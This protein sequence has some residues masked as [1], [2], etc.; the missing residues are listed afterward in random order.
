M[1]TVDTV[2]GPL[3]L[4]DLGVTLMHEHILAKCKEEQHPL[5][6]DYAVS[7]LMRARRAGVN[8][9]VEVTPPPLRNFDVIRKVA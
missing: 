8:T 3:P 6:V 2:R 7:E 1:H 5:A 4:R 9:I